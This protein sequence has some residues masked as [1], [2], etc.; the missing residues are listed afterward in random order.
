MKY[1]TD[2]DVVMIGE[3]QDA[4]YQRQYDPKEKTVF[5]NILEVIT[6]ICLPF[7]H[8]QVGEADFGYFD[9]EYAW[10]ET[11]IYCFEKYDLA[12][13]DEFLAYIRKKMNIG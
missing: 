1:I 9:G 3:K 5:W 12:L 2:I 7:T 11:E 8:E 10:Y 13:T 6:H 4:R